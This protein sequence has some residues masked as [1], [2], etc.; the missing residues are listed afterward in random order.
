MKK[1][2]TFTLDGDDYPSDRFRYNLRLFAYWMYDKLYNYYGDG[3]I[4]LNINKNIVYNGI[5][6]EKNGE[7]YL[8]SDLFDNGRINYEPFLID[9][10]SFGLTV[11][12]ESIDENVLRVLIKETLSELSIS[13]NVSF[14]V[15]SYCAKDKNDE[16]QRKKAINLIYNN[17]N[18]KVP[19]KKNTF[20]FGK[21]K[22]LSGYGTAVMR[23]YRRY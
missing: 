9:N 22:I 2:Y 16:S 17:L 11:I 3:F 6:E 8:D 19:P 18:N 1:I 4:P 15:V 20:G 13:Y 21:K 23:I 7:Y 5:H 14:D 12:D 10:C